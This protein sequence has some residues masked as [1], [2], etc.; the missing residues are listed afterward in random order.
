MT[1]ST[2]RASPSLRRTTPSPTRSS[3][4]E[5]GADGQLVATAVHATGGR[6]NGV[7]HLPSQNSI[8]VSHGRTVPPGRQRRLRR[9]L[10]LRASPRGREARRPWRPSA[11]LRRASPC[12]DDL[13]YVLTTGENS[14][15]TGFRLDA[16]GLLSAALPGGALELSAPDADPAQVDVQPGRLDAGRQRARHRQSDELRDRRPTARPSEKRV[17]A[18][19]GPTPYGFEFT[20]SG[21]L[22]VTEAAGGQ[23]VLP[24]RPPTGSTHRGT[25][26]RSAGA[27]PS[28]AARCAGPPSRRTTGSPT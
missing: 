20:S 10:G 27:L 28:T 14:G 13:V 4:Y 16:D 3:F 8:V 11:G 5:R 7:P 18:S 12:T 6:G 9:C 23:V 17:V 25:S 26:P 15:V 21:S 24:P 19:E 1:M 22:V 2:A